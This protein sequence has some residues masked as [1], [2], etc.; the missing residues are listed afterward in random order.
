MLGKRSFHS[1]LLRISSAGGTPMIKH[2]Y[3]DLCEQQPDHPSLPSVL[4][5]SEINWL[6]R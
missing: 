5:T 1:K 2:N 4:S 3:G 6:Y